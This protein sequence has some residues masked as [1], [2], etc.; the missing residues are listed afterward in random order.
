MPG[1]CL[2]I[3]L[4]VLIS[5]GEIS[6][7]WDWLQVSVA[8]IAEI[9]SE[10]YIQILKSNCTVR[11]YLEILN[12]AKRQK[13]GIRTIK[14]WCK[15][16][17]ILSKKNCMYKRHV[18]W[19]KKNSYVTIINRKRIKL[20]K[21]IW[22]DQ[23]TPV[24]E[25]DNHQL[26]PTALLFFTPSDHPYWEKN[27]MIFST[28]LQTGYINKSRLLFRTRDSRK[29]EKKHIREAIR[30]ISIKLSWFQGKLAGHSCWVTGKANETR[31]S[32]RLIGRSLPTNTA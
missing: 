32:L 21:T 3:L 10:L 1:F 15:V 14:R 23:W 7:L 31:F 24:V 11:C 26:S 4:N 22:N 13:T 2:V 8:T 9:F 27:E 25:M 29:T 19:E 30:V 28:A 12:F 18:L 16:L 6:L 20:T 17:N 5:A